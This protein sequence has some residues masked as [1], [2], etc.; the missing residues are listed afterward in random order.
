MNNERRIVLMNPCSPCVCPGAPCEQCTFGY[1]PAT[2]NHESMKKLLLKYMATEEMFPGRE[3]AKLYMAYH[4]NWR[5]EIGDIPEAKTEE[6]ENKFTPLAKDV[7]EL[8]N[9]FRNECFTKEEAIELTKEYMR[10]A[11]KN[12]AMR[13]QAKENLR[14]SIHDLKTRISMLKAQQES[15]EKISESIGRMK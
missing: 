12:E 11:F 9:A 10:V 6:K 8:Y 3:S 1:R 2:E 7:R 13:V 5:D 14:H 4:P 15:T